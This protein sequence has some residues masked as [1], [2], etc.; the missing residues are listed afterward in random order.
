MCPPQT[1]DQDVPLNHNLQGTP[2][3]GGG[4]GCFGVVLTCAMF[5]I[6][7]YVTPGAGILEGTRSFC[8]AFLFVKFGHGSLCC[9]SG[10]DTV[11][12]VSCRFIIFVYK[13]TLLIFARSGDN[14]ME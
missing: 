12:K 14:P 9:S 8:C 7:I 6:R 13:E 1:A 4:G 2:H 5:N 10:F 3:Q 11:I